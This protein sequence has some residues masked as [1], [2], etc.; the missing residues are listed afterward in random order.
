MID[1]EL[2]EQYPKKKI[3][4]GGERLV[5]KDFSSPAYH[6]KDANFRISRGEI[7]GFAGLVG[8]GRTELAKAVFTGDGGTS[9]AISLDGKPFHP[10]SP[11]ASV[12]QGIVLIPEDR[13][14]EG[15]VSPF[16]VGEKPYLAEAV[17]FR[18]LRIQ[19]ESQDREKEQGNSRGSVHQGLLDPTDSGH[20]ERRKSAEGIPR[21]VV[22]LGGL[23]LDLRRADPGDR[24][25]DQ[26]RDLRNHG[27]DGGARGR[28]SGSSVPISESS[29][30]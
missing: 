17:A 26:E 27:G 5:A 3:A 29:W 14:G 28:Q 1:K 18:E 11:R 16:D 20:F 10:R 7:V 12:K 23:Y 24:R 25:G 2:G 15:V 13:R 21:Q 9:G 6:I 30:R 4:I 22:R 19:V 8:S